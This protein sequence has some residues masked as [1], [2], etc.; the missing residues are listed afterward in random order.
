MVA[1][2]SVRSKRSTN[3]YYRV[4]IHRTSGAAFVVAAVVVAVG[5]PNLRLQAAAVVGCPIHPA[6][7]VVV[8][9]V[10]EW[11][12][13]VKWPLSSDSV[14]ALLRCDHLPTDRY[15]RPLLM[16]AAAVVVGCRWAV[17]GVI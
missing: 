3:T 14:Y 7:A 15:V 8:G 12:V 11:V 16:T 2:V 13:R 4:G 10:H 9:A 1:R 6:A 17:R 5:C